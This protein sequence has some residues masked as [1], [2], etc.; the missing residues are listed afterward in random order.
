MDFVRYILKICVADDFEAAYDEPTESLLRGW[1]NDARGQAALVL[2]CSCQSNSLARDCCFF[3]CYICSES[4]MRSLSE[5]RKSRGRTLPC[6]ELNLKWTGAF[7]VALCA[8][9]LMKLCKG[10]RS[11]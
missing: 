7:I 5:P 4:T 2:Y 3:L 8:D 11:R 9:G 10:S 1:L 6:R